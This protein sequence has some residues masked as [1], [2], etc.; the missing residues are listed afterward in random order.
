MSF[1]VTGLAKHPNGTLTA[2]YLTAEAIR[3]MVNA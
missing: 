3:L 2:Y 1:I